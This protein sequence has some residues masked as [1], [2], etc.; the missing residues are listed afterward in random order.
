M[1]FMKLGTRPDTFFTV[2]AIRSIS[3]EEPTDLI[4]QIKNTKYL[5]HKLPMLSKCSLLQLLYQE[6]QPEDIQLPHFPADEE[7]FEV[8]T[9]FCYGMAV[10]LSARNIVA[11]RSAAKYLQIPSLLQ[12]LEAFIDTCILQSWKDSILTLQY[13]G[14]LGNLP[15]NLQIINRCIE[16]IVIKIVTP[17]SR[18]RWSFTYTRGSKSTGN[19]PP[20]WWVE[21]ISCL[22]LQ[23]YLRVLDVAKA[24]SMITPSLVGQALEVYATRRLPDNG[25]TIGISENQ[26]DEVVVEQRQVLEAIVDQIPAGNGVVSGRFLIKLVKSASLLGASIVVKVRIIRKAGLQLDEASV[27][28]LLIPKVSS[29]SPTFYDIDLV[30]ELLENFLVQFRRGQLPES[31]RFADMGQITARVEKVAKLIDSYL[32][33]VARDPN[34]SVSKIVR[35]AE[36]VPERFRQDHDDLYMAIDAYLKDHPNLS[37]SD[38]KQL[39]GILDC[40]KLSLDVCMHA[41]QNERLPLRV[42]VQVLFSDHVKNAISSIPDKSINLRSDLRAML[43]EIRRK[44]T[45]ISPEKAREGRKMKT[46]S[47]ARR[48]EVKA[49]EKGGLGRKIESVIKGVEGREKR[50]NG[51]KEGLRE[52]E[53]EE[54]REE[55]RRRLGKMK[56]GE[57]EMGREER[58]EGENRGGGERF[59]G[60]VVIRTASKGGVNVVGVKRNIVKER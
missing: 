16:S 19:L 15:E 43:P 51:S 48:D 58:E 39:C 59:K 55:V 52:S 33:K 29:G 30:R 12:K 22:D 34:I 32:G 3:S 44:T 10:D 11:V 8:C 40:Q 6:S 14:K 53:N 56:V 42:V 47:E 9:K 23:M 37:K 5:L 26:A 20:D 35:L 17:P 60:G 28:D 21:D 49:K 25:I 50:G 27:S 2:S 31:S 45:G 41:V 57:G 18:V 46:H 4:I 24:S 36:M 38:R 13:A 1:K 7:T 54:G